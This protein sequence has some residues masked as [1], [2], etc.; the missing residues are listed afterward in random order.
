MNAGGF[1]SPR[2]FAVGDVFG[3][4]LAPTPWRL[5]DSSHGALAATPDHGTTPIL[6]QVA[7]QPA[8]GASPA[9]TLTATA[10][11]PK[12]AIESIVRMAMH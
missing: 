10:T 1:I 4:T 9:G 8:G 6:F 5:H 2:A 12:G 3:W 7:S 11:I